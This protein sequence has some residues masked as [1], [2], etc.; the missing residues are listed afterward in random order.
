MVC[1]MEGFL[2]QK[3]FHMDKKIEKLLITHANI[4]KDEECCGFID[5]NNIK[6]L[7]IIPCENIYEFPESGFKISPREF[8]KIKQKYEIVCL[9]HSHPVGP[10]KFSKKD[11]DQSE[12]LC[13]PI[14]L[15]SIQDQDF[16]IYFP[17]SQEIRPFIGREY[18]HHFQ[19]CW[20]LI[21]DYYDSKHK[22]F[23]RN[24]NFY[25]KQN[26]DNTFT[27][28]VVSKITS[29]FKSN[30]IKKISKQHAEVNDLMI[31]QTE[32]GNFSHF[33]II[34]ENKEFMHHQQGFLSSRTLID[35]IYL[36]K[37]HSVYRVGNN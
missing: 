3:D 34:L 14:C 35:D 20:K 1:R 10:A 9:Y 24:F 32:L 33:G 30:N 21:Y 12:E 13:L 37:I 6:Q 2:A 26:R 29:F 15:Y 23:D 16:N 7:I 25:L 27:E 28:E 19:N 17:Q 4:N 18:I 36:K 5:L 11:L 31:F 22:L 8:L